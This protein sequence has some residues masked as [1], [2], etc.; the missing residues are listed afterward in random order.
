[1]KLAKPKACGWT[2]S[3]NTLLIVIL[4]AAGLILNHPRARS[5]AWYRERRWLQLLTCTVRVTANSSL[6][7][8]QHC[9]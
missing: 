1:V 7:R 4:C 5:I 2:R 9:D 8:W 6:R 3:G